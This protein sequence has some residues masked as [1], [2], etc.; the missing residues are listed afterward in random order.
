MKTSQIK[1]IFRGWMPPQQS[2][3]LSR[4][5]HYS[6]PIAIGVAITVLAISLFA[7]ASN[8]FIGTSAVSSLPLETG[9]ND[10]ASQNNTAIQNSTETPQENTNITREQAY[11]MAFPFILRCAMENNRTITSITVK[12]SHSHDLQGTRGGPTMQ[13]V[14]QGNVSVA[15]FK[16]IFG[17]LPI[18]VVEAQFNPVPDYNNTYPPGM[19]YLNH[20]GI[21]T[22]YSVWIW[23][24]T[25]Q[26]FYSHVEATAVM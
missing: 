15:E 2:N 5:K 23:A 8:F 19:E 9:T 11:R 17:L 3:S 16:K 26:I 18:W 24:D 21:L 6:L 13:Q 7:A 10:T 1:R 25:G 14:L 12:F 4:F 22:G 20:N